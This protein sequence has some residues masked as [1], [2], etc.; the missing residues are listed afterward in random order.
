[1]LHSRIVV[2]E[3]AVYRHWSK[4]AAYDIRP[5]ATQNPPN[6]NV[7]TDRAQDVG[8]GYLKA[9]KQNY[10]AKARNVS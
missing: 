2:M 1:M 8:F 6:R 5:K 7:S 4:A 10:T 3:M 9:K